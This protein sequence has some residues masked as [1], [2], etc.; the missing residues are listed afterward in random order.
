M[1]TQKTLPTYD[2]ETDSAGARWENRPYT[3]KA[4]AE[5]WDYFRGVKASIKTYLKKCKCKLNS[6]QIDN[7]IKRQVESEKFTNY[8]TEHG[9]V[10]SVRMLFF[11]VLS[12]T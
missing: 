7:W 11:D 5:A 1:T 8:A 2:L 6:A 3:A 10:A 12:L 4:I 9:I